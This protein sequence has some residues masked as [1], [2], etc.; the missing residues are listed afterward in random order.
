MLEKQ[1][2]KRFFSDGMIMTCAICVLLSFLGQIFQ[3]S[4]VVNIIYAFSLALVTVGY[5]ASGYVSTIM[6]WLTALMGFSSVLR[7]TN[8]GETDYISH[9]FIM[10]CTFICIEI[11]VQI[12]IKE[13]NAK[14]IANLFLITTVILLVYYYIGPL[15]NSYFESYGY[16]TD[17]IAL[18]MHNPNAAGMWVACIFAVTYYCA[19][20]FTDLKRILFFAIAV[21]TIPIILATDS[22]NSYYACLLLLILLPVSKIFKIKKVPKWVLFVIAVLPIIVFFFYMYVVVEN[23]SFWQSLFRNASIEKG[24]NTRQGVWSMVMDDLGDCFFVGN[25][26]K[27]YDRQMH[28]SLM[29]VYCRHGAA[30]T[31]LTVALIYKA[32]VQLQEKTSFSGVLSL[33]AILFTGCF[34]ASVFVGVAGLYLMLLIVPAMAAAEDKNSS[35]KEEIRAMAYGMNYRR[36]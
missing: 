34:E 25:Y 7:G 33:A 13:K 18:N 10:M 23:M 16:Y 2:T 9:L 35:R 27:Y 32:L 19:F 8:F 12:N 36:F 30:V 1:N 14:T 3:I 17:A 5:F 24:I 11:G 6:I 29:T 15:K 21:A 31:G 20:L 4:S 26:P 22:R 28:N